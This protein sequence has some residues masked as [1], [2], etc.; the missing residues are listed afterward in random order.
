MLNMEPYNFS[1]SQMSTAKLFET[2][3]KFN[4]FLVVT[5]YK[6]FENCR[7]IQNIASL[8]KICVLERKTLEQF[9]IAVADVCMKRGSRK[10]IL[11]ESL[12]I[13]FLK[14]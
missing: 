9:Q 14:I 4:A 5:F 13:L 6:T 2:G 3:S 10:K 8:A 1:I 11:F 12:L 7:A